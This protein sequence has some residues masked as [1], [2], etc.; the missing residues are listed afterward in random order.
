MIYN[1][2]MLSNPVELNSCCSFCHKA[3][4]YNNSNTCNYLPKNISLNKC[5]I[6]LHP[7][8]SALSSINH[9]SATK[10]MSIYLK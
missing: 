6:N 1:L 8:S 5:G 9:H 4:S 2:K 10:Y 3:E 7:C